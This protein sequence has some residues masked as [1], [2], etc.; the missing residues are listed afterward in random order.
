MAG[1]KELVLNEGKLPTSTVHQSRLQFYEPT[2]TAKDHV[3][4]IKTSW[5]TAVVDGKL[6]QNQA[7]LMEAIF[8]CSEDESKNEDGS[9][10]ITVDPYKVRKVLGGGDSE[11]SYSSMMGYRRDIMKA[12]IELKVNY[13]GLEVRSMSPIIK[14]IVSI[15]SN[16]IN[17]LNGKKRSLWYV[18]VSNEYM[19]L[20]RYDIAL[21]YNP[22]DIIRLSTGIAQSIARHV[23]GHK[24]EP[25]G[26]W[27]VDGLLAATGVDVTN[28]GHMTNA[29]R[30]LK[31]D[32]KKLA[33]IGIFL[34]DKKIRKR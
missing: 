8:Y 3:R 33:D 24:N 20:S 21:Y 29:R 17:P 32:K 30:Y 28:S 1:L 15:K 25:N 7:S 11:Y 12:L 14:G 16:K 22:V 23:L 13:S 27:S 2:K 31:K 4:K 34:E 9:V 18:T 19:L 6:G 10:S 5:G 26:G